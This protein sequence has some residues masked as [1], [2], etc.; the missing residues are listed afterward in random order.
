MI[1]ILSEI[2]SIS[3]IISTE[4]WNLQMYRSLCLCHG[5]LTLY[6]F[7][8]IP[9]LDLILGT[10][11]FFHSYRPEKQWMSSITTCKRHA[12]CIP[13]NTGKSFTLIPSV[14]KKCL[15]I[16]APCIE[17]TLPTKKRK[18][19][20]C[21]H[22]CR[23]RVCTTGAGSFPWITRQYGL[24]DRAAVPTWFETFP[25]QMPNYDVHPVWINKSAGV[26]LS[27]ILY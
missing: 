15:R 7:L 17:P 10:V 16:S 22:G 4:L 24:P 13:W 18:H 9:L 23:A 21:V 5:Y 11:F 12:L 1:C 3:N 6:I 20:W 27:Y 8:V 19:S 14:P 26:N 2:G 25:H